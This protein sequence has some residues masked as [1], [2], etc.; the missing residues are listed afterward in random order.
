MAREALAHSLAETPF[1]EIWFE[2]PLLGAP[3]F[4]LHVCLSNETIKARKTLP[5]G[6]IDGDFNA[7]FELYANKKNMVATDSRLPST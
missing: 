4:Y 7:A 3:R 5:N 1:S 2:I 6:L